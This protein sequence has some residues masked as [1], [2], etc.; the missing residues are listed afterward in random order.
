MP[1]LQAPL[2]SHLVFSQGKPFYDM[3][4]AYTTTLVG[5]TAATNP[6]APQFRPG[7]VV[8]L[9]GKAHPEIRVELF[10]V[11]QLLRAGKVSFVQL[12]NAFVTMLMNTAYETVKDGNDRSPE[13]E[14]FRH[15][16][17]ASS[18]RNRFFFS[19]KEPARPAA[20]RGIVLDDKV[21]GRANPLFD[22]VCFGNVI[23][24]ADAIALLWDVE[25]RL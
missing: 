1:A 6:G 25:Q 14:C 4:M 20:W 3:V 10:A 5:L 21:K 24:S 11:Q 15:V 23:A 18:H 16:R 2:P 12:A 22:Q 17:N 7:V 19:D 8:T 9:E 13:F